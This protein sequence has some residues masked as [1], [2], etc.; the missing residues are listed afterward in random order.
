MKKIIIHNIT[1]QD[2]IDYDFN[3][4]NF[5]FNIFI[6]ILL[7]ECF[8]NI[9]KT[10]RNPPVQV[11]NLIEPINDNYYTIIRENISPDPCSI[12]LENYNDIEENNKIVILRCSHIFHKFCIDEW[13]HINKNCPLCKRSIN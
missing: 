2:D 6:L 10:C 13:I 7:F 4:M 9:I 12:C 3:V 8:R 5:M 11:D 1:N